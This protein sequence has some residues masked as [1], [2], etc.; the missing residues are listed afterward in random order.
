M[1]CANE[2]QKSLGAKLLKALRVR[3]TDMNFPRVDVALSASEAEWIS[4]F[5]ST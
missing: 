1:E 4:D 3:V 2:L 5:R